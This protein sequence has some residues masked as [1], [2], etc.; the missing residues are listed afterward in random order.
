MT[1]A[2]GRLCPHTEPSRY[3]FQ[4]K[5]PEALAKSSSEGHP[6]VLLTLCFENRRKKKAF[7]QVTCKRKKSNL[8]MKAKEQTTFLQLV[9]AA[10][11]TKALR[12]LFFKC[13][14][15][16]SKYVTLLL[17][18]CE[19]SASTRRHSITSR[20]CLAPGT[21]T[22]ASGPELSPMW[23]ASVWCVE[24]EDQD[25]VGTTYFVSDSL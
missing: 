7:G 1:P 14:K 9:S 4:Y 6:T 19:T 5:P 24:S 22:C 13:F 2:G 12:N 18:G 21:R 20:R 15:T 23:L 17:A 10:T 16:L 11:E 8:E 25:R 3:D